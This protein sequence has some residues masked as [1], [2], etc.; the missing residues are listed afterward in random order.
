MELQAVSAPVPTI[1][2]FCTLRILVLICRYMI[3][4]NRRLQFMLLQHTAITQ[5]CNNHTYQKH[6]F[7]LS[8][9]FMLNAYEWHVW[10]L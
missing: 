3:L 1:A 2:L 7:R 5:F 9:N 4:R 6:S 8:K 10:L